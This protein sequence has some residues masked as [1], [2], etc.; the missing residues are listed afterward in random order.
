MIIE[1]RNKTFIKDPGQTFQTHFTTAFFML[2]KVIGSI[3]LFKG[4]SIKQFQKENVQV[5]SISTSSS[6]YKFEFKKREIAMQFKG[7]G[8]PSLHLKT[9]GWTQ[10]FR[11]KV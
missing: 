10:K 8:H 9:I 5:N 4:I 1:L 2:H 7:L 3:C 11:S 6:F